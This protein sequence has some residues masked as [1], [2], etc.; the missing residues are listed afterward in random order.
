MAALVAIGCTDGP[1]SAGLEE[2]QRRGIVYSLPGLTS[3]F[4]GW[5]KDKYGYWHEDASFCGAGTP[6]APT[7]PSGPTS[8]DPG[9]G[10]GGGG[11]S[12]PPEPADTAAKPACHTDD[13]VTDSPAVQTGFAQLWAASSPDANMADRRE[14]GGWVVQSAGSLEV[15]PFPASWT[16]GACGIDAP[17]DAVPPTG[18]VAWVHTHPYRLRER[19]TACEK[20]TVVING[21]PMQ[22]TWQYGNEPSD[23]DGRVSTAWGIPGY[24]LDKD[25]VT[26][27]VGDPQSQDQFQV[28][29]QN[30]R[31]GY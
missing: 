3:D 4:S 19:M 11:G 31:C 22:A 6:T 14:Q 24:V 5:C 10:S 8:G 26:K 29:A 9:A 1:T 21:V 18:T 20:V 28:V 2:G 23:Y 15:V 17:A 25:K 16:V 27:F 13:P 12:P 7:P 30:G